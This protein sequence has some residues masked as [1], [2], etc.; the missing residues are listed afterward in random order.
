MNKFLMY[1][2]IIFSLMLTGCGPSDSGGGGGTVST[3]KKSI[4]LGYGQTTVMS[5]SSQSSIVRYLG[6]EG[7]YC[8]FQVDGQIAYVAVNIPKT[9]PGKEFGPSSFEI[10]CGGGQ[11]VELIVPESWAITYQ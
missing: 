3:A 7:D 6:V 10:K 1:L 5:Y 11:S 8:H 4:T 2:L 9:F